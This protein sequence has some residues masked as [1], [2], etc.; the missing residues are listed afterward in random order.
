MRYQY[1]SVD[2]DGFKSVD[3]INARGIT[4][5]LSYATRNG[6]HVHKIKLKNEVVFQDGHILREY[7]KRDKKK[8]GDKKPSNQDNKPKEVV[9][10]KE[11]A[12]LI[13]SL[14]TNHDKTA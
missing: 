6:L 2:A 3:Y 4:E 13:T 14:I 1:E 10:K 9:A 11:K 12:N 7:V 5:I 8:S